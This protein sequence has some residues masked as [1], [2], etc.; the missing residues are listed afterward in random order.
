[1]RAESLESVIRAQPFLPFSLRLADGSRVEVRHPELIAHAP[2][3]RTVIVV[4]SDESFRVLD[5]ALI[6]ELEVGPPQPAGTIAENPNG[7]E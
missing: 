5:V 1:M 6:I 2:G 3:A 4:G 7:G